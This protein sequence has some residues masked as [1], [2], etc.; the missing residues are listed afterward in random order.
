M[1][2]MQMIHGAPTRRFDLE[3][4][5]TIRY[6]REEEV[7]AS[8]DDVYNSAYIIDYVHVY[9]LADYVEEYPPN[10]HGQEGSVS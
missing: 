4:S 5:G 6:D 10:W 3:R 7:R 1:L 9:Q 2:I 8:Y